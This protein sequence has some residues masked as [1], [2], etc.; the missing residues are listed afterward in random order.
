MIKRFSDERGLAMVTALLASVV[1]LILSVAVVNLSVH[2]SAESAFDRKR[3]QAVDAAEAGLDDYLSSLTAKVGAQMCA[4][5][6]GTTTTTP[7]STYNVSITLYSTWPPD[8][9]S[10][11]D[12]STMTDDTLPLGALVVSKGTS[13][14]PGSVTAVSRTM[15]TEVKLTPIYGGLGQAIFSDQG[16]NFQNQFTLNGYQGNDGDVYT[17]GDFALNNNTKISGSV[18]AQGSATISQG[19]V[20]ANVWA[21]MAVSLS[22]GIE[23]FGDGTSSQS[24]ITLSNNSTIDGNAKAGTTITGGT[25]KGTKTQNSPSG[26]P[27]YLALPQIPYVQQDWVNAGYQIHNSVLCAEAQAFINALPSGNWVVRVTPTCAL[28]WGNNSVVN[29]PGNLAIIT[30]G[31]ITTVNQTSWNATSSSQATMYWIRPYQSG[32]NCGTGAYNMTSSNYTNFNNLSLFVYTQCTINFANNNAGGAVGQLI[33][34]QVNIT[35]QATMNYVPIIVP[36]YNLTGFNAAMSYIREIK[37]S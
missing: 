25:V 15:E 34:G 12:C 26:A 32:L 30:D 18:Y 2:N 24:S 20:K 33:G 27:P 1:V 10:V 6:T 16:I 23:V 31:S 9:S 35:N 3:T 19:I 14:I 11:I 37:N 22:S 5:M 7:Q 8:D 13:V 4:P 21:K 36:G 17:N 29:I 28:T